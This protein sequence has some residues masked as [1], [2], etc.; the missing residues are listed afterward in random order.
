[1]CEKSMSM[2]KW[3]PARFSD[4]KHSSDKVHH[5]PI[6]G[7]TLPTIVVSPYRELYPDSR[8]AKESAN[9]APAA[10][11]IIDIACARRKLDEKI[12]EQNKMIDYYKHLIADMEEDI[13]DV[14][15]HK[16]KKHGS[17]E[18]ATYIHNAEIRMTRKMEE[19]RK[20]K[21]ETEMLVKERKLLDDIPP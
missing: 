8:P 16:S 11:K 2:E 3:R 13:K 10:P 21:I 17:G 7:R 5:N 1:M 18:K 6:Q 14:K 4:E 12:Q 20:A 15:K 19:L 9:S